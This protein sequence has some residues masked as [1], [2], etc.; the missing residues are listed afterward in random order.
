[1]TES[2]YDEVVQALTDMHVA[3]VDV[4]GNY[5]DT[6]DIF[7]DIAAQ[8]DKMSSTDQAAL[9]TKLSGTR[10]QA[11]F[12]SL[13]QNFG[14]AEKA[15][16]AMGKAEGELT[17]KNEVF[18]NS[19]E[20]RM[21]QFRN[22]FKK[23]G[24]E[25]FTSDWI[26]DA[27]S[28]AKE[29][30]GVIAKIAKAIVGVVNALGGVKSTLAI[31]GTIWGGFKIVKTVASLKTLANGIVKATEA[32]TAL[33]A[34]QKLMIRGNS[35]L[36]TS[37]VEVGGAIKALG[38]GLLSLLTSPV[39][40]IAATT[41]AVVGL[42]VAIS[43]YNE[44][45]VEKKI[46]KT[47]EAFEKAKQEAS[48]A[49]KKLA[50][51]TKELDEN[52]DAYAKIV[53]LSPIEYTNDDSL[54]KLHEATEELRQ[55]KEY[56]EDLE[57]K[58]V[59]KVGRAFA[60]KMDALNETPGEY[61]VFDFGARAS[62]GSPIKA[63]LT[64]EFASYSALLNY[65]NDFMEQTIRYGD[66]RS[67]SDT[68]EGMV[69]WLTSA[70]YKGS[71]YD[72]QNDAAIEDFIGYLE[73]LIQGV[74]RFDNPSTAQER[75]TNWWLDE[76][77]LWIAD[78]KDARNRDYSSSYAIT[79]IAKRYGYTSIDEL[80][81]DAEKRTG[82]GQLKDQNYVDFMK[83]M[84]SEA[85]GG[86]EGDDQ[87]LALV[88]SAFKRVAREAKEAANGVDDFDDSVTD[89]DGNLSGLTDTTSE[90][91]SKLGRAGVAIKGISAASKGL[92]QL[93]K[94]YADVLN[95]EDFDY[96]ALVDDDFIE[97]F[98]GLGEVFTNFI[99]TVS[100]SPKDIKAC[101]KAFDD[102]VTSY[103]LQDKYIGDVDDETKQLIISM[104]EEQGVSNATAL[105]NDYL[106]G[107]YTGV[108][109]AKADVN[110]EEI[111]TSEDV[112][113]L[114]NLAV[115]AKMT[116]DSLEKLQKVKEYMDRAG[117]LLADGVSADDPIYKAQIR[118]ANRL[119]DSW[120]SEDYT[121]IV[122]EA[123]NKGI[124]DAGYTGN[125]ETDKVTTAADKAAAKEK[126]WF[127]EQLAYHKHLIAMEQETDAEYFAWLDQA[128]KQAYA[129]GIIELDDYY[130]YQEEVF[131][132]LKSL[133]KDKLNDIEK[134]ISFREAYDGES[135]AIIGLYDEA[136]STVEKAIVDARARGLD[137]NSDYM[138]ELLQQWQKYTQ[139]RKDV[140]EEVEKN[141]KDAIEKLVDIRKK[142]LDQEINDRKDAL[143]KE[144]SDL[145]DFYDKQKKMLQDS[146]DEE[147]YL[148]E[149]S[150]K[151]K[152]VADIEEQLAALRY[153]DS[154]WAQKK[155]AELQQ[156]LADAQKE[157][158]DFER[159]HAR[160]EALNFLD[161]QQAKQEERIN[162]EI[163]EL[164]EM[165]KSAKEIRDEVL[166]DIKNGSVSLYKDMLKWNQEYGDGI[167]DTI[168]DAW[169][170]AYQ[171]LY[172]YSQLFG[173]TFN[174]INLANATGWV[175]NLKPV[176]AGYASGTYY[177]TPG[178]HPIDEK[179][180]ETY[181]SPSTG[182]KYKMFSGGEK[183]LTAKASEFLYRF[184]NGGSEMLKKFI[185]SVGG[186]VL[187]DR[188][189]PLMTN[190]EIVMGD[191]YIEGDA[192]SK[193]VS[194]IR[195][196]QRE[197]VEFML[198]EFGK[199]NR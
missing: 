193:T 121:P 109:L 58:D 118:A 7:K 189:T 155:R 134:E 94:I 170:G 80:K 132:G 46:S 2:Q 76:I 42:N 97:E 50:E 198:K 136:I 87:F 73:E 66:Y 64:G 16:E 9:A 91:V 23:L 43:R 160:D 190:N 114:I 173:K 79:E 171:A 3:L 186:G 40:I 6:Y 128:Y 100:E 184:A 108:M 101:Q 197:S 166:E 102:L 119:L 138:Q 105:V 140:E 161:E 22:E 179:G 145:K 70:N 156:E 123:R 159:D 18:A 172:N 107:S 69:E 4:N 90:Y 1:M 84:R 188:L 196:A 24:T 175:P 152:S 96:S 72:E 112:D 53:T 36:A 81:K 52:R 129:E 75:H 34:V 180:S 93:D 144:L 181:F 19:I 45:E 182:G 151:R 67:F 110:R 44:R 122:E 146:Y 158:S 191:I 115:N 117:R 148:E 77:S 37:S 89:A 26:K 65:L 194:E 199:L 14:E 47:S 169:E 85:H 48:E 83:A 13:V 131:N 139:G 157:L 142:M 60:D 35:S 135:K 27:V 165:K 164:E 125:G 185:A 195:R 168:T 39:G 167:D 56:A 31:I 95:G 10:M 113:N 41:A 120:F 28:I 99:K 57:K 78:L 153:D 86:W 17:E 29:L 141:A 51:A 137:N 162:S 133:V 59:A 74:E 98:G 55:Q 183:V 178:L 15:Y 33:T 63:L 38:S 116:A 25:I 49:S 126:T 176:G 88:E 163:E 111:N 32:G 192:T 62:E 174:G 8:W 21:N 61:G 71:N 104:L 150:E 5:R 124:P 154:A 103:I 20:G 30:L 11:V 82:V 54:G 130:K 92:D 143:N 127:D 149:Q 187:N 68:L 12:Y 147:D 106:S 177:A